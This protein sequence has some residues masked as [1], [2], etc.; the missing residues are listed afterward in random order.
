MTY[1]GTG[2]KSPLLVKASQDVQ[3][4]ARGISLV[5]YERHIVFFCK[6]KML[7]EN[8]TMNASLRKI[9][10]IIK[11]YLADSPDLILFTVFETV[12]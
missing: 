10:V 6:D 7:L 2:P 4:V 1:T 12:S 8:F 9:I 3:A 11:T 5:K